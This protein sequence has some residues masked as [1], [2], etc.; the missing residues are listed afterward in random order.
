MKNNKRTKSQ[1]TKDAFEKCLT[2][3]D[4]ELW[5]RDFIWAL[6]IKTINEA[7]ARVLLERLL[8]DFKDWQHICKFNKDTDMIKYIH[9]ILL[10]V[11]LEYQEN[12]EFQRSPLLVSSLKRIVGLHSTVK[13]A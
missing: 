1:I 9:P 8:N 4:Y 5:P 2:A 7:Q 11:L 3:K 12:Y 13:V 10:K 6:Q